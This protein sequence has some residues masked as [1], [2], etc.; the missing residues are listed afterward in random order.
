MQFL[1]KFFT[2]KMFFVI[3]YFVIAWDNKL[4]AA[5]C[6]CFPRSYRVATHIDLLFWD[7]LQLLQSHPGHHYECL[8]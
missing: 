6:G 2:A 7:N 1:E 3:Y 5:V 8:M 4:Y